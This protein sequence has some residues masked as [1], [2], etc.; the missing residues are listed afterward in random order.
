LDWDIG[1]AVR[2]V[3]LILRLDLDLTAVFF[4]LLAVMLW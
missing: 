4:Y 1:L 2:S 3:N